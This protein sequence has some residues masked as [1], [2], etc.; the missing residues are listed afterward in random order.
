M[1]YRELISLVKTDFNF[2]MKFG[3][4][5]TDEKI[6]DNNPNLVWI[7]LIATSSEANMITI[8]FCPFENK[9]RID[10]K[11]SNK[12]KGRELALRNYFNYKESKPLGHVKFYVINMF[13]LKV[14]LDFYAKK[15]EEIILDD[16]IDVIKNNNWENIPS[17]NPRD[18]Y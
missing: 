14:E 15:V 1:N 9:L 3:Y 5:F 7:N 12:F 6:N 2:L 16:L 17:F 18:D 10:T 11:I 13:N 4:F 8:S